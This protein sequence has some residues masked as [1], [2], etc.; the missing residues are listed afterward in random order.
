VT[1][2]HKDF[3][4][5]LD[6][7][8][9]A[10]RVGVP[11]VMHGWILSRGLPIRSVV[12][13][14]RSGWMIPLE[15]GI[16][17]PDVAAAFPAARDA[18]TSGFASDVPITCSLPPGILDVCA[19]LD[20]GSYETVFMLDLL[21][22]G[23]VAPVT[24]GDHA[25]VEPVPGR[26]RILM[27]DDCVPDPTEGKGY[28]RAF[29]I[30]RALV[31]LGHKVSIYGMV[32][33]PTEAARTRL[34][35]SVE[36]LSGQ[37]REPL[38]EQLE[39]RRHDFDI[40]LVSRPSNLRPLANYLGRLPRPLIYDAEGVWAD[41]DI[42]QTALLTDLERERAAR[43]DEARVN[44]ELA[45][46]K[47]ADVILSVSKSEQQTLTRTG[48]PV[49][50]VSHAVETTAAREPHA[51]RRGI[52]FVGNLERGSP[53]A[54]SVEWFIRS[55]LP[56]VRTSVGEDNATFI[57]VGGDAS[58]ELHA[59][60][61]RSIRFVGKLDDLGP[62]M[63][64]ARVFV[65]PTRFS[66]G[67]ALKLVHAAAWGIPTVATSQLADQL[68]WAHERELLVADDAEAFAACCVRLIRDEALWLRLRDAA[69]RRVQA[70][71]TSER[72][73]AGLAA[74]LEA[75]IL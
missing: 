70:E 7:P 27:V 17:R 4:G 30:V 42:L 20:D 36:V 50:L 24:A 53:N 22:A 14:H 45:L 12:L 48:R 38:L 28:A 29:E 74:A 57:V 5:S 1:S 44:A 59:L 66:A 63:R 68:E 61:D 39:R 3:D 2:S 73:T 16:S 21:A 51:E 6:H 23:E 34:P 71:F 33:A 18:G 32:S 35:E 11:F 19:V 10:V 72:L 64:S 69:L 47:K 46:A 65:A 26:L 75:A 25:R 55:I 43:S 31:S 62:F 41:S 37:G 15:S 67:I 8:V 13:R 9:S 52:V 58:A 60:G 40:T 54:D 56:I 49:M